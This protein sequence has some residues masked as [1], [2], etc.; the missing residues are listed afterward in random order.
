MD[1]ELRSAVAGSILLNQW[2]PLNPEGGMAFTGPAR[3]CVSSASAP[4]PVFELPPG[5]LLVIIVKVSDLTTLQRQLIAG[6]DREPVT[7][8]YP[9][10]RMP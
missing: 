6:R 9:L 5:R 7:V 2:L 10:S 4:E 8:E 1:I 3:S